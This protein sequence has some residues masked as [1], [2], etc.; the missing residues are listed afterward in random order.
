MNNYSQTSE[1][2][3]K[4]TYYFISKLLKNNADIDEVDTQNKTTLM[5]SIKYF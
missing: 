3:I 1:F 5:I 4:E 2:T